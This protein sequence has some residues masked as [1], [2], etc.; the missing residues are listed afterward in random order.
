MSVRLPSFKPRDL[1]ALL[2]RAGF[3]ETHQDSSHLFLRHP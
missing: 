3:V 2:K 1:A